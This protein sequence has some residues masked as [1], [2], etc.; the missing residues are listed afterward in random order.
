MGEYEALAKAMI[1][2]GERLLQETRT[3]I[4]DN[5]AKC[6]VSPSL[7][8]LVHWQSEVTL[9]ELKVNK[10]NGKS[11]VPVKANGKRIFKVGMHG[12]TIEG[13]DVMDVLRILGFVALI[14]LILDRHGVLPWG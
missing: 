12:V 4:K 2:R 8:R 13:F 9:A 7:P 6:P 1:E 5:K 11:G 14:Y 10:L 3:E